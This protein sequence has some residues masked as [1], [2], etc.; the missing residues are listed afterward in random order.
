DGLMLVWLG[1][2]RSRLSGSGW[3]RALIGTET[4]ETVVR[5]VREG[6]LTE[7]ARDVI[8]HTQPGQ[9][10]LEIGSGTGQISLQLAQAGRKVTVNDISKE[11]LDFTKRCAQILQLNVEALEAN[12]TKTLPFPDNAFDCTWN[13]GLLEHFSEPERRAMLREWARVTSGKL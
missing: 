12:A 2:K 3:N 4:L 1:Q 5:E 6:R 9:T 7:W 13:S 8:L 10:V 11:S